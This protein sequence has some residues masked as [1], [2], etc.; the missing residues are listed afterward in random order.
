[1]TT[2]ASTYPIDDALV[3]DWR[4]DDQRFFT[5]ELPLSTIEPCV[6]DVLEAVELRPGVGLVSLG[7]LRFAAGQFGP[8]SPGFDEV[9]CALHVHPDLS[10]R[11]P[12]PKAAFLVHRM[13]SSSKD[14]IRVDEEHIAAPAS[15]EP[16]L[17][18]TVMDDGARVHGH[19]EHGP[20]FD[21]CVG[22]GGSFE[23]TC[24]W[25]QHFTATR[26]VRR[27]AWQWEGVRADRMEARN[28]SQLHPHPFFGELDVGR[29][30]R[31]HRQ[32]TKGSGVA[33]ERFFAMTPLR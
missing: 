25:G 16:S 30:L 10:M 18:V 14:L 7:W 22:G 20:I 5:F 33:A 2:A 1:M 19:S 13:W 29:G 12:T 4:V 28:G 6:P 26:G 9:F 11:M 32:M 31:A 3:L 24:F 23:P 15:W 17:R 27:G 21:L 8:D